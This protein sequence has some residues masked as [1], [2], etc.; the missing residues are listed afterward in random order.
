MT[1]KS[2]FAHYVHITMKEV[3]RMKVVDKLAELNDQIEGIEDWYCSNCQE[4]DCAFCPY[5]YEVG[6]QE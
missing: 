1:V 5:D 4:F 3:N 2:A 6:W